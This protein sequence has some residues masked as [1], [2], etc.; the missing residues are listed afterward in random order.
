MGRSDL[1]ETMCDE[2]AVA[3]SGVGPMVPRPTP[4]TFEKNHNT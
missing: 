4:E 2:V 3:Q 1:A